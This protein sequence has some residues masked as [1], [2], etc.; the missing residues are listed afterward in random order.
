M[1]ISQIYRIGDLYFD[2]TN[3]MDIMLGYQNPVKPRKKNDIPQLL[4]F[5]IDT[6]KLSNITY[7]FE[8]IEFDESKSKN[9]LLGL[10][11][12]NAANFS[13]TLS[14][15]WKKNEIESDKQREAAISKFWDKLI[16]I[17]KSENLKEFFRNQGNWIMIILEDIEEKKKYSMI[18]LKNSCLHWDCMIS[19]ILSLL[20]LRKMKN[21]FI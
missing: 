14:L 3:N 6:T 8:I 7:G 17:K 2:E 16:K 4:I 5:K 12:G 9:Y 10:S 15:N 20:K 19:I 13:L 1:I 18:S 21:T 11:G